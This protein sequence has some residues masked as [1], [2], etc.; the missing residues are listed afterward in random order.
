[1]NPYRKQICRAKRRLVCS[2]ASKK[3]FVKRCEHDIQLFLEE[4]PGGTVDDVAEAFGSPE[5]M[6]R[7]FMETLDEQE[8]ASAKKVRKG[9]IVAAAVLGVVMSVIVLF[10]LF[11]PDYRPHVTIETIIYTDEPMPTREDIER[12]RNQ[13]SDAEFN[14]NK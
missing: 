1:M 14:D 6:A 5:E 10:L 7:N 8:I 11:H 13:R 9:L 3:A 2:R 4:N 12:R